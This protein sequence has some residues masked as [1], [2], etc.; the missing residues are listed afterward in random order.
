MVASTDRVNA[1]IPLGQGDDHVP[2]VSLGAMVDIERYPLDQPESSSY[3]ALVATARAELDRDGCA[4]I[5]GFVRAEVVAQMTAE[6]DALADRRDF[7]AGLRNPYFIDEPDPTL[8]DD[9]P[10]NFFQ[11]RSNQWLCTDRMPDESL[12][13]QLY[14]RREVLE[15]VGQILDL[16][17]IY[18]Y[19]DPMVTV[20]VNVQIPGDTLPWHFDGSPYATTIVIREPDAGGVFEYVPFLR[21]ETDQRFDAVQ[22]ALTTGEGVVKLPGRAGDLQIFQ[23]WCSIHRVTPVEAGERHSLVLAYG[24]EPGQSSDWVSREKNFGR[25]HPYHQMLK[26]SGE[27]GS[28]GSALTSRPTHSRSEEPDGTHS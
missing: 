12:M 27:P 25:L 14:R 19:E 6:V 18:F 2:L 26:D 5:P 21:T 28:F 7:S 9:H 16:Q 8:P 20:L 4:V 17:P 22:H 1:P 3:A 13:Y 10:L 23:G 15:F 24:D 11:V